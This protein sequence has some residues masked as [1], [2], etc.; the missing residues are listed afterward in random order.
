MF[1]SE[2]AQGY[3]TGDEK[4]DCYSLDMYML[5]QLG[6][7]RANFNATVANV[8]AHGVSDVVPTLC[9]GCGTQLLH[10]LRICN[11]TLHATSV[12]VIR[13]W[14]RHLVLTKPG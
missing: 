14:Q 11:L 8:I 6:H 13:N 12:V 5:H 7:T 4:G 2:T 10:M 3:Y 9:L 1:S